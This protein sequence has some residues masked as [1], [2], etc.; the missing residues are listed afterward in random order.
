M[1]IWFFS[2]KKNFFLSPGEVGEGFG[3]KWTILSNIYFLRML[4]QKCQNCWLDGETR[5]GNNDYYFHINELYQ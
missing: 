5:Y 1:K 3:L 4:T 2:K